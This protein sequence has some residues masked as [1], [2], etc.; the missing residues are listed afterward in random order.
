MAGHNLLDWPGLPRVH[1]FLPT[2]D[3]DA[4]CDCC[5]GGGVGNLR[6]T[7]LTGLLT[8]LLL[9]RTHARLTA[10]QSSTDLQGLHCT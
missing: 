3:R 10:Q 2:V 8:H 7:R 6:N 5:G 9:P 4:S 1:W